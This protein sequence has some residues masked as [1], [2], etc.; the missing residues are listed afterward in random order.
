LI[1]RSPKSFAAHSLVAPLPSACSWN[2]FSVRASYLSMDVDLFNV[3][4]GS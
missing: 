1:Q 3:W 2:K 4:H